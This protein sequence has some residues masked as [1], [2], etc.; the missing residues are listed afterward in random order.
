MGAACQPVSSVTSIATTGPSGGD[1]AYCGYLLVR[2]VSARADSF[3]SSTVL[4]VP[5]ARTH[6]SR[7][8]ASSVAVDHELDVW[9]RRDVPEPLELGRALGFAIDRSRGRSAVGG[10]CR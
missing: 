4:L 6:H 5:A 8:Q 10:R 3:A 1:A 7:S 9:V 2:A